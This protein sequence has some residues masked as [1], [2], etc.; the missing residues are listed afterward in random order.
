MRSITTLLLFSLAACGGSSASSQGDGTTTAP[1][2]H[3]VDPNESV[4][5]AN[6]HGDH[7][8]TARVGRLG[9]RLEIGNGA[10]LE[11]PPG[12]LSQTV[13]VVFGLAPTTNAFNNHFDEEEVG[14]TLM[15]APEL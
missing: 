11:I 5:R 7:E 1:Q 6:V 10:T 2:P 14:P 8:A 3:Q 9:G 12:A 13:E 15:V 4:P